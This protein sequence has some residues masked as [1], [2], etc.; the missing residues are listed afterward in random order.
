MDSRKEGHALLRKIKH[1]IDTY[2]SRYVIIRPMYI[3]EPDGS[4][5][6]NADACI[7]PVRPRQQGFWEIV[8]KRIYI[9][10]GRTERGGRDI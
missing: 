3:N 1:A 8:G 5:F 6:M 2:S 4:E 9:Y 10:I 7:V